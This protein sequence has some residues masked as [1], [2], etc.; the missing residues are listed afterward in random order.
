[1]LS[2]YIVVYQ[3]KNEYDFC[4]KSRAMHDFFLNQEMMQLAFINVSYALILLNNLEII[5]CMTY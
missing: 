4:L 1:M 2:S 5:W 3:E